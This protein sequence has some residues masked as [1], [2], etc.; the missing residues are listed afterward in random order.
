MTQTAFSWRPATIL[1]AVLILLVAGTATLNAQIEASAGDAPTLSGELTDMG[2]A[3]GGEV[4]I[5][6]SSPD[7]IIAAGGTIRFDGARADHMV[8]AGGEISL[9]GIEASDVI[10]S[11]GNVELTSG[12]VTD[13]V[14]IFAGNIEIGEQM[15]IGGSAMLSGGNVEIGAPIGGELRASG[16]NVALDANVAGDAY[17]TGG[18]VTIGEGVV[19]S[20][21][22]TYAAD[23]FILSPGAS[24]T[25]EMIEQEYEE[26]PSPFSPEAMIAALLG[27]IMF[28]AGLGLL[29]LIIAALFPGLMARSS[30]MI[31]DKP[32]SSLGIGVLVLVVMPL[33]GLAFMI[34]IIGISA[35]FVMLA[36]IFALVPFA[37][38]AVLYH[39]GMWL[40]GRFGKDGEPYIVTR[41][42]W[43]A[44]AGIILLV[45]GI[46]PFLGMLVWIVALL[47]GMGAVI[48]RGGAALADA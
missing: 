7:D 1:L 15:T 24:V 20:G 19:I 2:F 42:V 30:T 35:G 45:I 29:I 38:A 31:A 46:V 18:T 6:A 17:L 41:I 3:A 39:A 22:L 5:T 44:L 36:L 25:G 43:T 14:I 9:T 8:A 10:L 4:T 12:T 40:R 28:L 48:T 47:F 37:Y 11:G 16:G 23:E 27:A 13:D 32:L 34:S 21:N 26:R 33:M